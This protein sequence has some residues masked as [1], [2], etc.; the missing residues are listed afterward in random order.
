MIKKDFK[1]K[2]FLYCI[3]CKVDSMVR[4]PEDKPHEKQ[5]KIEEL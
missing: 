3:D 5:I 1:Q 2:Y 4:K